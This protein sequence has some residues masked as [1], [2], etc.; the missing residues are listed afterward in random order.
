[1]N[2]RVE[3]TPLTLHRNKHATSFQRTK[4]NSIPVRTVADHYQNI[5]TVSEPA[6]DNQNTYVSEPAEHIDQ[7]NNHVMDF[8]EHHKSVLIKNLSHLPALSFA[9]VEEF[10]RKN[11]QS[12]EKEQI[13][14]GFKYYSEEYVHS[15]SGYNCWKVKRLR[16][17][18]VFNRND[19]KWHKI[20][21]DRITASHAGE[22]AKRRA[23]GAKLAERLQSTRHVQTAAMKR[24]YRM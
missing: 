18:H 3:E 11:S 1:M 5:S 19:P 13:T 21:R 12:S 9:F 15:V 24:G 7:P 4:V 14:K 22:I 23:D 20:R 8:E 6:E 10:I 2:R 17:E 16:K